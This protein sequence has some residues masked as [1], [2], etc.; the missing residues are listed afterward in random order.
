MQPHYSKLRQSERQEKFLRVCAFL[1][2]YQADGIR[3]ARHEN[4][5]WYLIA[6]H[7]PNITETLA[8]AQV[9]LLIIPPATYLLF[10]E[11]YREVVTALIETL[12]GVDIRLCGYRVDVTTEQERLTSLMEGRS[13]AT[14]RA[15]VRG[16]L[17]QHEFS[18]LVS[19]LTPLEQ[20]RYRTL[21]RTCTEIVEQIARSISHHPDLTDIQE[22]IRYLCK[23]EGIR[24]VALVTEIN[25]EGE[26]MLLSRLDGFHTPLCMLV[27]LKGSQGG[28]H[29]TVSRLVALEP[30]PP[31]LYAQYGAAARMGAKY[32][33]YTKAG[34][35]ISRVTMHCLEDYEKQGYPSPWRPRIRSRVTGNSRIY[36]DTRAFGHN[37]FEIHQ[38]VS[39][40]T[41][42]NGLCASWVFSINPDRNELLT[43]STGWPMLPF[44]VGNHTAYFPDILHL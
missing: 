36:G 28:L 34:Q 7:Q 23:R 15:E 10:N 44:S 3:L 43:I 18:R 6:D 40:T 24:G 22:H 38:A 9:T 30:L 19:V 11:R 26:R 21:C 8:R 5:L 29:A 39:L 25:D 2:K 12:P 14:D 31:T 27:M 16:K 35:S 37:A 41:S 32:L 13:M 33:S 17:L 1:E 4:I 20:I 42:V